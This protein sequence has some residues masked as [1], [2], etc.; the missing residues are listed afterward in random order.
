MKN[1]RHPQKRYVNTVFLILFVFFILI[2][3]AFLKI[4][5]LENKQKLLKNEASLINQ[6][7][8]AKAQTIPKIQSID[9]T[10][11]SKSLTS[12]IEYSD[13]EC[14]ACQ[15]FQPTLT[16]L[17][18]QYG[19]SVQF[20]I[21]NYPL[22]Q[23]PNAILEAEAAECTSA[24]SGNSAYFKYSDSLYAKTST[25]QTFLKDQLVSLAVKLGLPKAQFSDCLTKGTY[26]L[27]VNNQIFDAQKAG[28]FQL[29]AVFIVDKN[30]NT[31]L[32]SGNQPFSIY[33]TVL[34]LAQSE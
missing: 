9:H 15:L 33:K 34:D 3:V 32:I 31:S 7:N 14:P 28:A 22:P 4:Q 24:I 25:G 21:R 23:H 18:E 6:G 10:K 11:S 19:G 29:P 1:Q 16:K 27:R 26:A 30:N 20:V 13:F 17:V 12:F 5:G 2:F 8:V